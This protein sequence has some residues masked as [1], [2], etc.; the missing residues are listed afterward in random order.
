MALSDDLME[1]AEVRRVQVIEIE[2]EYVSEELWRRISRTVTP[3]QREKRW[4]EAVVGD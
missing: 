4:V 3:R 1:H 2:Y